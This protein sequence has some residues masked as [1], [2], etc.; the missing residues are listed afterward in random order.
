MSLY[1]LVVL[2]SSVLGDGSASVKVENLSQ[3]NCQQLATHYEN[4]NSIRTHDAICIRQEG[5]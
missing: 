3:Y 2:F 5:K 1:T 4:I